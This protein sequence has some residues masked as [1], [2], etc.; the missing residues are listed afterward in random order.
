MESPFEAIK[1]TDEK[2]F[3]EYEKFRVIQDRTFL[4]D[5]DKLMEDIK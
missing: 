5:F 2:A 3:G 4:S 1:Q